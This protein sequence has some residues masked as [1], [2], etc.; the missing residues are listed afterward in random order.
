RG[1][2]MV[3]TGGAGGPVRVGAA[4]EIQPRPGWDV[5]AIT[6]VPPSA[7]LHRGPV[8]LEVLAAAPDPAGPSA[9]AD[10]YVAEHLRPQLSQLVLATPDAT[11]LA[12]G[13]PA[14][15]FSY[16]GV[17]SDGRV[18]DG[19]VVAATGARAS[20]IFDASAPNGELVTVADDLKTMIDGAVIG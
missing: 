18:V 2:A 6:T 11:S 13:V 3:V 17:T 9:L 1:L 14:V 8:V 10:R 4:I 16:I 20:A 7:R 19:L 12:D 5:E 15:R